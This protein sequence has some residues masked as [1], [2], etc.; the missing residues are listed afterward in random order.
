[1][2]T[3]Y[4]YLENS[5]DCQ[6]SLH[7]LI[8]QIEGYVPH[9][10][11]IKHK[12]K[13]KYGDDI[14]I[15]VNRKKTPT[16]CFRNIGH[17]ILSDN[18]YVSRKVDEVEEKLRIVK[19]AA[20]IIKSDIAD[21]IY[22]NESYPQRTE[23]LSNIEDSVP[24]SLIYNDVQILEASLIMAPPEVIE[25]RAFCQFV[26]DNCDFNVNSIDGYNI[27]YNMAGIKCITPATSITYPSDVIERREKLKKS[28]IVDKKGIVELRVFEK[29]RR[30]GIEE[31]SF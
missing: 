26:F 11:T 6:F 29:K 2:E 10:T 14:I 23:F 15:T 21:C 16:V 31:P 1:M 5:D 20:E 27:F 17:A 30:N 8:N 7:E 22:E 4:N 18:W 19:K 9:E 12:L 13:E 24:D 25:P 3:I 28:A